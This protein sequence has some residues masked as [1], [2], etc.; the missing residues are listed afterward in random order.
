MKYVRSCDI[1]FRGIEFQQFRLQC[2]F[3]SLNRGI[4]FGRSDRTME[5]NV[6]LYEY[7][8]LWLGVPANRG[9]CMYYKILVFSEVLVVQ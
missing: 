3:S 6:L 9:E 2:S 4:T 1:E 8:L 5:N 7:Q